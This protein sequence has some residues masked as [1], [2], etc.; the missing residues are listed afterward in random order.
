MGLVREN[1]MHMLQ[2]WLFL[3]MRHAL[4]KTIINKQN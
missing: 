4:S 3:K 1:M 2:N